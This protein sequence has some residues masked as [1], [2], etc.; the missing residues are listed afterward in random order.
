MIR[1]AVLVSLLAALLWASDASAQLTP[2]KTYYGIN[3]PMAM[4][5]AAPDGVDADGLSVAL[6]RAVSAE[7]VESAP[8]A[9]GRVDLASLFPALWSRQETPLLYAQ[10]M[11]G[12]EKIGPAVVLAPMVTPPNA[13]I[14]PGPRPS[15]RWEPSQPVYT[16]VKA[17]VDRDIIMETSEGP[18]RFRMRPDQA[19]NTCMEIMA[20]V[21][22][23][24]YEGIIFH[25]I[26]PNFVIQAGDPIGQGVG[27]SGKM[28]DLEP[29]ALPHDF[30]V[31]SMARTNQ[32]NTNGSQFFVCLSRQGTQGLD[33]DYCAFGEA[34]EGADAIRAIAAVATDPRTNRPTGDAPRIVSARLEDAAPY[35]TGP[36]PVSQAQAAPS[37]R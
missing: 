19:T 27:G 6:L 14:V 17:W 18:I 36:A 33:G 32:P 30:G 5:V 29:S 8:V 21:D 12:D 9:A 16:G 22:G 4:T 11:A 31:L 23:G 15:V 7:V 1:T 20:L 26:M 28:F 35:G 34:I 37:P 2:D 13:V 3:R 10:L 24:F 25:R